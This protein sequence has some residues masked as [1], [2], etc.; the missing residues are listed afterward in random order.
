MDDKIMVYIKQ[1]VLSAKKDSKVDNRIF[2]NMLR[3]KQK[4]KAGSNMLKIKQFMV[5]KYQNRLDE[6][7]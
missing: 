1:M 6:E 3:D 2:K 5:N 4:R 7:L